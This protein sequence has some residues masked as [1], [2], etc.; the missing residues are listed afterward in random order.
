MHR[1]FSVFLRQRWKRI[2]IV[3]GHDKPCV[4]QFFSASASWTRRISEKVPKTIA[5]V[6]AFATQFSKYNFVFIL[7][8]VYKFTAVFAESILSLINWKD[9]SLPWEIHEVCKFFMKTYLLKVA[10]QYLTMSCYFW[11]HVARNFIHWLCT[12]RRFKLTFLLRFAARSTDW[13]RGHGGTT[14]KRTRK[15]PQTSSW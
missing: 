1:V 10:S 15:S 2:A 14:R 9:N 4:R 12:T 5:A 8:D 11:H 3:G 13:T 6:G 7:N